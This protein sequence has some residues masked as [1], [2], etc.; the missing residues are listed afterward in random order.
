MK[1]DKAPEIYSFALAGVPAIGVQKAI[2]KIIRGEYENI[3]RAFIP[4]PPNLA[5]MCRAETRQL[6]DD[7]VRLLEQLRQMENEAPEPISPEGRARVAALLRNFRKQ[8]S[9]RKGREAAPN[10]PLGD[11]DAE[12]YRRIIAMK[13][14]PEVSVEQYAYRSTIARKVDEYQGDGNERGSP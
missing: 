4:A 5:A 6:R 13:D 9:A 10:M 1:E 12:Y 3:E 2:T 8:N 14:A 11:E 7:K